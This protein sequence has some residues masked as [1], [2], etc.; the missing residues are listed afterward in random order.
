MPNFARWLSPWLGTEEYIPGL[1]ASLGLDHEM[2]FYR[3]FDSNYLNIFGKAQRRRQT[4]SSLTAGFTYRF[5]NIDQMSLYLN[6]TRGFTRSN[7][8]VG[9]VFSPEG[10]PV[11]FQSSGLGDFDPNFASLGFA[12]QF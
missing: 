1:T 6:Y 3:Y 8:P 11:A 12:F 10:V 4:V 5:P 2:R 9:I 7:L